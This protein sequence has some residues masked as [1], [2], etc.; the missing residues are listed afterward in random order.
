MEPRFI[1]QTTKLR[2]FAG[3][4]A[5]VDET[6]AIF[7]SAGATFCRASYDS[8]AG[9]CLIECWEV[10]PAEQGAVRWQGVDEVVIGLPDAPEA[11]AKPFRWEG[12]VLWIGELMFAV[13]RANGDGWD[14]CAVSLFDLAMKKVDDRAIKKLAIRL[15]ETMATNFLHAAGMAGLVKHG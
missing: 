6:T 13:V 4:N 1:A 9:Q 3:R 12:D 15:A 11:D 10:Q 7:R 2:T 14:I 8:D 5:W